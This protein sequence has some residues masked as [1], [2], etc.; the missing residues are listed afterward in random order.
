[1][2]WIWSTV[3]N[4]APF[5]G[6]D[7]EI[8]GGVLPTV[9][10][11]DAV[12]VDP[13]AS[14][15]DA[16]IVCVPF[17]RRLVKLPPL[18]MVPSRLEVHVIEPVRLPCSKSLADPWK[19]T[20]S[21]VTNVPPFAGLVMV[22]VGGVFATV[23]VTEAVV[24]APSASV[25][26]AV[27]T[28]TPFESLLV[29][30]VPVPREPSLS[31]LQAIEPVRPPSSKSAAEPWNE[32]L[33]L[34]RNDAPFDGLEIDTDGAEFVTATVTVATLVIPSESVTLAVM[35]WVPFESLLPTVAPVPSA[36]SLS[37]VHEIAPDKEP[38]SGSDAVPWNDSIWLVLK[39]APLLGLWI[40]T[41][42]ALLPTE[43]DTDVET[44]SPSASVACAVITWTPI[45]SDR[46]RFPPVPRPP[47]R[48]DVQTIELVRSPWS[49]SLAVARNEI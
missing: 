20:L 18:P 43:T 44:V 46:V 16:V 23:I 41:V 11:T 3:L 24:E 49:K 36:P 14:V 9:T 47:E 48:L 2:N 12:A 42:G 34:R 35:T 38:S 4:V 31:E 17:D 6:L 27:M 29:K 15:I 10:V 13:S 8:V 22:M 37:D 7:M 33:S 19:A 28:C 25:A 40:D 5:A 39:P 30:P 21:L 32:M 26:R 45:G 1:V